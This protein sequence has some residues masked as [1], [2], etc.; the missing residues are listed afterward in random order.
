VAELVG[1]AILTAIV[2]GSGIMGERLAADAA[3]LVLLANSLATGAGLLALITVLGPI[4]GAHFNP[5]VTLVACWEGGLSRG[6]A[7][8][9]GLVQCLGAVGGAILANLMFS[10]P[11]V[12]L[13][14]KVRGGGGL[15]L[16]EVV[17]SALLLLVIGLCARLRPAL[18][19]GA[20][21]S[22]IVAGYW[23]TASTSFANP[24]LTLARC[25]S[26]TFAGIELASVPGF[27]VAQLLGAAI[28]AG[29]ARW[30][31]KTESAP[32]T[33]R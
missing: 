18:V 19:P 27:I 21:A 29:L 23:F 33:P 15:W 6:T 8:A 13:S 5:L 12:Q 26:D 3:G 17:A 16:S 28:G 30:L 24:A 31:T 11:A 14:G 10:L 2:I 9:Y 32:A 1:T 22:T 25:L 7:L 4:S 20:V